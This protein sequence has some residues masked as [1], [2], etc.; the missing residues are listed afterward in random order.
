MKNL[1]FKKDFVYNR[2]SQC[3]EIGELVG[4]GLLEQGTFLNFGRNKRRS[5]SGVLLLKV[6]ANGTALIQNEA[7]IILLLADRQ[8]HQ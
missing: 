1:R 6:T 5:L 4:S 8:D 7:I 3:I 2:R